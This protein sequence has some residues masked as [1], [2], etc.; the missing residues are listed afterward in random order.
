MAAFL[1]FENHSAQLSHSSSSLW[2][3]AHTRLP[4]KETEHVHVNNS[5]STVS[6]PHAFS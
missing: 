5:A 1:S 3:A 2:D 6:E 4:L